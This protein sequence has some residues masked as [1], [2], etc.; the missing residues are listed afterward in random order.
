L[1]S[2]R[3][4]IGRRELR[5]VDKLST[6]RFASARYSVPNRMLGHT[7][8]VVATAQTV[9]VLAPGTGEVLAEHPLCAPGAS[10]ILDEHYGRARPSRPERRLRARTAAEISFL[11][12]GETAHRWLR[13]AAASGNTRLGPE[14]TELAALEAA[15]GRDALVAALER[16]VHFGRW[17]AAGVRSILDAGSGVATLTAPGQALII[18]LPATKQRPLS[19]YRLDDLTSTDLAGGES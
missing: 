7:V 2:L 5:K 19:A 1:P 3:P 4:A 12:L 17:N 18:E 8:E 11:A 6:I 15:H 10:S 14:L 13:S 16:A 9:T